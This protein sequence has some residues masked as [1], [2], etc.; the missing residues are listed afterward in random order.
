LSVTK[1]AENVPPT[2]VTLRS[3]S[4]AAR[5]DLSLPLYHRR[6]R[7]SP[8]EVKQIL[9]LVVAFSVTGR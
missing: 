4:H 3:K 1:R 9:F 5:I 8:R 7:P 2:E 6:L